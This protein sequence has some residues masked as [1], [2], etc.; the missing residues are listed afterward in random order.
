[1]A[2]NLSTIGLN[3][4][5]EAG[6]DDLMQRLASNANERLA[7]DPGDYAIWRSRTGAEMWFHVTGTR[8]ADGQ[9]DDHAIIGF[10]PF[11]EGLS[12][13]D[14]EID[15]GF[16]RQGENPFEGA[17]KAWVAPDPA[18]GV[19]VHPIVF[20]CIDFA[21][22]RNREY[23]IR[24]HAKL[25]AFAR[26]VGAFASEEAFY[27]HAAENLTP[28][29]LERRSASRD[30]G[31]RAFIPLGLFR[32]SEGDEADMPP[33]SAAPSSN[34]VLTG[35]VIEHRI[36]SDPET[37]L[38]FHWMLVESLGAT[39]DVVADPTVVTGDIVEGGTVEVGCVIFGRLID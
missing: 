34:A 12:D 23:P 18:N 7:C 25:T 39:I 36:M 14:I 24:C 16:Q 1:V 29:E 19:G 28:V 31:A 27:A 5:T 8:E 35:T 33:E 32:R 38:S 11:F 15:A 21:A 9:L 10:T 6:F 26:N 20:D 37:D 17:F 2:S 22:H 3:Y 30:K 4:D 13:V